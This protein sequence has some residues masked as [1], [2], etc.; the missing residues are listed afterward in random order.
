MRSL[1]TFWGVK[2]EPHGK[3]A[4]NSRDT[5]HD[6]HEN[7][8]TRIFTAWVLEVIDVRGKTLAAAN[9]KDEDGKGC[10]IVKVEGGHEGFHIKA[11]GKGLGFC[12]I[13]SRE[14]Q[15]DVKKGHDDLC[16]SCQGANVL[17]GADAPRGIP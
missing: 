8:G 13:G 11:I 14:G 9:S 4:Q 10:H 12:N 6:G 5:D 17:Q 1:G 2:H 16:G 3:G 7:H 15:K